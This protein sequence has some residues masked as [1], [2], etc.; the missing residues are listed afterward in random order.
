MINHNIELE[1]VNQLTQFLTSTYN[2]I[3]FPQ[4]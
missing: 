2:P 3:A 4:T 1:I